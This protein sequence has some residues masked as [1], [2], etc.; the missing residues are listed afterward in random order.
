MKMHPTEAISFTWIYLMMFLREKNIWD[1]FKAGNEYMWCS[2]SPWGLS[3]TQ[4]VL[5]EEKAAVPFG[6]NNKLL[7]AVPK[8][9]RSVLADLLWSPLPPYLLHS[10]LSTSWAAVYA[11]IRPSKKLTLPLLSQPTAIVWPVP[12]KSLCACVFSWLMPFNVLLLS[13]QKAD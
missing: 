8:T 3:V 5:T 4:Y 7:P 11:P 9:F 2:Y 10:R 13:F 1:I 6:R 12:H